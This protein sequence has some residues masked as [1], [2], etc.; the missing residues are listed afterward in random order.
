LAALLAILKALRRAVGRDLGSLGSIAA[1]NLFLFVAL[2]CYGALNSGQPPKSAEPFFVLLGFLLLFPL[3]TDPLG[4][5]PPSRLSLWPLT[6]SQWLAL[7]LASLALSPI[8]WIGLLILLKTARPMLA[9]TFLVF[10]VS[11]QGVASL[12]RYAARRNRHWDLLRA[13]PPL[14]GRLGGLVRK[15]LREMLSVMD[16]YAG[17]LLSLG[18]GAYRF[19]APHPDPS[20]SAIMSLLVALS[21]STYA[22][23]L[24]GLELGSG[25]TRYHLLPLAGWQILLA[26]DLAFLALLL[27][28]LLPLDIAPGMTL[29]FIALAVGHHSSLMLDL[30]HVRWRFTGGRLL[31]VTVL[32]LVGGMALG[33]ME[34]DRGPVVLLLAVG[35]YLVSLWYYGRRWDRSSAA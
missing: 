12:A 25:V 2:L 3:S 24:F 26:K 14:P 1:N 33:F 4:R 21:L 7:R 27:V 22:Q 32:Q 35:A 31:F 34:H 18:G 11:V 13:I 19:F 17:A 16:P 30:P 23:S 9:L 8:T 15:N 28:L 6:T 29:G 5:I 20:A 10:A